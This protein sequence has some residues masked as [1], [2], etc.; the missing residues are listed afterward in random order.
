MGKAAA[1]SPFKIGCI[2]L[3]SLKIVLMEKKEKKEHTKIDK[4]KEL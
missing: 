2:S 3:Q 1:A 4:K